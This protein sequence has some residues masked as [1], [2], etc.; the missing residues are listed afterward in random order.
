MFDKDK[1]E[2]EI[3][4]DN[5]DLSEELEPISLQMH[6]TDEDDDKDK[7][8]TKEDDIEIV[9]EEQEKKEDN[10]PLNVKEE[11]LDDEEDDEEDAPQ[12]QK[13]F[14]KAQKRIKEL[15]EKAKQEAFARQQAEAVA[16][17]L[18]EA[19]QKMVKEKDESVQN[20]SSSEVNS[21]KEVVDRIE[22]ELT[23]AY[24]SGEGNKIAKAQRDLNDAQFKLNIAEAKK[25][26]FREQ[27]R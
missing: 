23:R 15:N 24:E 18:A 22:Q 26:S 16:T 3:D 10:K 5:I 6:T 25:A 8:T 2:T 20:K 17:Q 12:P 14:S 11:T 7:D 9:V 13:R 21:Y 27:S 19:L 1:L 4:L